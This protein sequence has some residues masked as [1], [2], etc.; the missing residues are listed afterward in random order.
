PYRTNI[1]LPLALPPLSRASSL[2][3]YLYAPARLRT[4]VTI[5]QAEA[6]VRRMCDKINRELPDTN[7]AH[8]AYMP[9]LRESFVMDLRPKILVII[10]AAL[11][12]L[13]IAAA[14]FAGVLLTRVVEREGEF[15]L[16][17]ALGASWRRLVRQQLMQGLVLA[18]LGTLCGLFLAS[19][20]TPALVAMSPEGADAT[21]SAMREFD[22]AVRLD[23]P[24][25]GF[26]TAVMF[27]VG[28]GFGF[29]PAIHA[30]RIDLRGAMN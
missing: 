18:L 11:C 19:W 2:N 17:R 25:F 16:R 22:Y 28:I 13:L 26:A 4:G 20:I 30:S 3:H 8:A 10:I 9:P 23:W 24:V 5:P 21:G 12:V 27:L 14:N 29:L 6:A 15:S 7:N 1:W